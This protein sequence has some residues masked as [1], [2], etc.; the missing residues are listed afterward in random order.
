MPR[1]YITVLKFLLSSIGFLVSHF[2]PFAEF[3]MGLCFLR[4][5][6]FLYFGL[7][8]KGW[9]CLDFLALGLEI[10]GLALVT[11]LALGFATM[12][13]NLLVCLD[14]QMV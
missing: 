13:A 5:W 2:E 4:I 1:F 10:I 14:Q 6:N 7:V 3:S 12:N 8:T 11:F 9:I